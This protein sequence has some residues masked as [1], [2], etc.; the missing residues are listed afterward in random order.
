M[1]NS[2]AMLKVNQRPVLPCAEL[3]NQTTIDHL[4]QLPIGIKLK[5]FKIDGANFAQAL[6]QQEQLK[7]PDFAALSAYSVQVAR[8]QVIEQ[9]NHAD[10]MTLSKSLQ[11][12]RARARFCWQWLLSSSRQVSLLV[13]LILLQSSSQATDLISK[14][15]IYSDLNSHQAVTLPTSNKIHL[16]QI[17]AS[18]FNR[19]IRQARETEVNSPFYPEAREDIY[20]WS[21]IILDIAQGRADNGD[22]AGAIAAVE[23]MPQNYPATQVLARRA[24][25]AVQVWQQTVQEQELYR[26]FLSRAK[27]TIQPDSASSY[28]QAIA[29]LRQIAPGAKE[30]T[31]AQT[32][33]GQWNQQIYL[34]AKKRALQGD[35]QQAVAAAILVSPNSIYHQ[36]AKDEIELR[37]KTIYAVNNEQ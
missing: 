14:V 29:I 31:A 10:D 12:W 32:L 15:K 35:F 7:L 20:R 37:I 36:L 19:A 24:A 4:T 3:L 16:H 33:I 30:Y 27:H 18:P 22:F 21:R 2:A 11:R 25:Q 26:D 28:N 5:S 13:L 8:N 17:Q 34:I 9:S 1:Q 23:L 6:P